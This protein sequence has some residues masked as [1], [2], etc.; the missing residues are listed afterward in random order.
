MQEKDKKI[1]LDASVRGAKPYVSQNAPPLSGGTAQGQPSQQPKRRGRPPKAAQGAQGA[2]SAQTTAQPPQ[3]PKTEQPKAE[4]KPKQPQPGKQP[5]QQA[6]QPQHAQQEPNRRG[7]PPKANAQEPL[8]VVFLGGLNEVGKNITM[9]EYK[10]DRIIVDCG[11]AFPDQDM[12]GVDLVIPDFTYIEQNFASIKGIVITHGHEDHIGSLPYLLKRVNIPIYSTKLTLGLIRGK[13]REHRLLE[14]AKL[15]EIK[16]GDTISLGGFQV[17]AIHVNHSI[18]DALAFA[19]T[20]GAGTVIQTGDYKIDTT[21]IDGGMIDL[22]RFADYGKKGV[23]ALLADS[24]NA[25]R[26]GYTMSERKVGESF[27]NLFRRAGN[28]RILVATFSSNVHRV[29]QIIDVAE[30]L[31]RKVAL[32]GRSLENVVNVGLE[33]GYLH[34]PEGLLIS[35]DMLNRYTPEQ[36]VIITT[37]SQGEPMS[38]LTRMALSDHRKVEIGPQDCV[39]ISATPI[40]GNEK[41]VGRVINELLK[42]GAQVVYESMYDVHVSGHACQEELKIMLGL[43]QPQYFIPVHGEQKHLTKHANLAQS[44]GMNPHNIMI[45]DNGVCLELTTA[46]MRVGEPVQAGPVFVDG[47]GVGDVGSTVLRDRKHLAQDGIIIVAATVDRESGQILTGPEIISKG[48]VY[49]KESE[50]LMLAAKERVIRILED[51][52]GRHGRDWNQARGR[53]REDVARLMYERT[54]RSPIIVPMLMEN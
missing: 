48:F 15:I 9:Y 1:V 30:Q 13:L 52:R 2:Q 24:T 20:C 27:D 32:L 33:L 25:E 4:K 23:L 37:G 39:I 11:L 19:I 26:P 18:P 7:R 38:A 34:V 36:L 8:K 40:P 41:T 12:P 5:Q 10:E 45:A 50:D 54:K 51:A 21:P 6:Q 53:I 31:G 42:L 46:E 28:R 43:V 14:K 29:Q 17:E 3:K 44:M 49:V 35:A 22:A 47:Y 16:P